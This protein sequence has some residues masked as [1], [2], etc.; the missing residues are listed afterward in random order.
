MTLR[1]LAVIAAVCPQTLFCLHV[2]LPRA[3]APVN[4]Y[5]PFICSTLINLPMRYKT[6]TKRKKQKHRTCA[7]HIIPIQQCQRKNKPFTH[8]GGICDKNT[9]HLRGTKSKLK[10]QLKLIFYLQKDCKL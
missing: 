3:K 9:M 10:E 2:D 7:P 4:A 5:F 1:L 8:N 6:P